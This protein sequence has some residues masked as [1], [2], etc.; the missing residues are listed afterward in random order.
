MDDGQ[1]VFVHCTGIAG[2]GLKTLAD[3]ETVE[4]DVNDDPGNLQ[5]VKVSEQQGTGIGGMCFSACIKNV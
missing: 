3:E 2:E 1:D 4:F 5:K